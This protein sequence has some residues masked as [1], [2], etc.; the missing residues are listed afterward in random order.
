MRLGSALL[1][2]WLV[3][4]AIAAGQRPLLHDVLGELR[5]SGDDRGHHRRRAAQL[6]R[7]EPQAHLPLARSIH[8]RGGHA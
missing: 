6:L 4:G 3:I 7:R 1:L 8:G 2:I 5:R